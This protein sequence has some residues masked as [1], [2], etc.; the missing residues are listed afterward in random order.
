[1]TKFLIS[2][3]CVVLFAAWLYLRRRPALQ[4]LPE[5]TPVQRAREAGYC[6]VYHRAAE[7]R[8]AMPSGYTPEERAAWEEG[9]SDAFRDEAE[10]DDDWDRLQDAALRRDLEDHPPRCQ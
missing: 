2:L 10:E 5:Q 3:A 4:P 8:S 7:E 1:M 6:S 9:R